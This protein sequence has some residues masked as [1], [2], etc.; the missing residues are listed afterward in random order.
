M[1]NL[2]VRAPW[3]AL[4][5]VVLAGALAT[6][7]LGAAFQG[8]QEEGSFPLDLTL[9]KAEIPLDIGASAI[10]FRPVSVTVADNPKKSRKTLRLKLGF[11]NSSDRDYFMYATATLLDADGRSLVIKSKKVKAD[12]DDNASVSFKFKLTYAEAERVKK[13]GFKYALEKD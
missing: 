13:C 7:A 11:R 10:S 4:A 6:P 12:D 8:A 5:S 1:R 9:A 2:S 3:A